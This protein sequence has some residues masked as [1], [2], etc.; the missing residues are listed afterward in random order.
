MTCVALPDLSQAPS[1]ATSVGDEAL[2]LEGMFQPKRSLQRSPL[3][4][5]NVETLCST[6]AFVMCVFGTLGR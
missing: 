4:L 1:F 6:D 5:H 2:P 3:A